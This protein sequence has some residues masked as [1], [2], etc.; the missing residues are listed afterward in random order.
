MHWLYVLLNINTCMVFSGTTIIAVIIIFKSLCFL[1]LSL[2][3]HDK[4]GLRKIKSLGE[5]FHL[6]Y[7]KK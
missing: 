5:I 2:S 1:D 7:E 3:K 6:S 4:Y